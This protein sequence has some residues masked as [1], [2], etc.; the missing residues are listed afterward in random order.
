VNSI[1]HMRKDAGPDEQTARNVLWLSLMHLG[2][3]E[4]WHQ[5]HHDRPGSARLGWGLTQPDLGWVTIL[6][7]EKVG[8]ATDVRR[9]SVQPS[10]DA[11][12]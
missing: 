2:Q 1:C 12:A 9:P 5:N 7:L 8:L 4:N 6:L 3:G 10:L 11:A